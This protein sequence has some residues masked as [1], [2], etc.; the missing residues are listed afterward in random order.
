MVKRSPSARSD[1]ART[2][3]FRYGLPQSGILVRKGERI[4]RKTLLSMLAVAVLLGAATSASPKA[5]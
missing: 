3:D 2:L 5:R 1:L 4:V